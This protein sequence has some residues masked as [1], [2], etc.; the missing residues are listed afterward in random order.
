MLLINPY[1]LAFDTGFQLSFLATLGLILVSPLLLTRLEFVPRFFG[2]REILVATLATQIMVL[3]FL[4]FSIG[5]FSVVAV[6]VN[7]LVLPMVPVAMLLTFL[8]GV[9]GYLSMTLALPVAFLAHSSLT[10]IILVASWF[11]ALPFASFLIPSF[12]F[13]L[14]PVVYLAIF[15]L[16]YRY[17]K[18]V[19]AVRADSIMDLSDWTIEEEPEI[20]NNNSLK[21]QA[22]SNR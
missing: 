18:L 20:K 16:V 22:V 6:L 15:Y 7:V 10:Y 12:P 19:T 4:L 8:T 21:T 9:V 3:P 1:L 11:A 14:V 2:V 5:E 13:W 17:R